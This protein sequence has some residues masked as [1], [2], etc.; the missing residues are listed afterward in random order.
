MNH[1]LACAGQQMVM[2][3]SDLP[4]LLEEH[5]RLLVTVDRLALK[6]RGLGAELDLA[7]SGVEHVAWF[8]GFGP[9]PTSEQAAAAARVA[10]EHEVDAVVGIGGGSCLDVAKVAALSARQ[11]ELI[12][13]LS[14]GQAVQ[15]VETLPLI[16]VP[17]TS[18]TGSEATHFAAIYVDGQKVSVAHRGMRPVSVVLDDRLHHAM[19]A[20]LAASTGCDALGQAMESLWAVGRTDASAA[21]ALAG[22]RLIADHLVKSVV[23]RDTDARRAVMFGA[24]LAGQAINLSKTTASHA[25][26]YG[27]TQRFGLAHGHAVAL[28]LGQL[29]LANANVSDADCLDP[30]GPAAVREHVR[31]ASMLLGVEPAGLPLAVQAL[32]EQVGLECCAA[33]LGIDEHA[34]LSLARQVDAVRLGN[35]PRQLSAEQLAQLLDG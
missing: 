15:G 14:R 27:M 18:G 20:R 19:P 17:T 23:E 28:T 5:R 4:Q 9:N 1:L 33:D 13:M 35:N 29:G 21:F 10:V 8:D 31:Q 11:P 7:L 12:D 34:C 3:V 32:L 25:M 16:A 30:R 24:H 26:S 6:A 2:S 22:G